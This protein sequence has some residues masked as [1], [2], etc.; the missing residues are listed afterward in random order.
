MMVMAFLSA[1]GLL[2]WLSIRSASMEVDIVEGA[3]V[4]DENVSTRVAP[5]VFGSNPMAQADILIELRGLRVEGPVGSEAFF[6]Q[7]P[8]QGSYLVKM[9]PEVM[10]DGL[11]I[12]SDATVTVTGRVHEMS[13]SVADAWVASGAIA[14][15]DRILAI[16]AETFLE[17]ERVRVTAQPEPDAN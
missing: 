7:V 16:F 4:V 9:P 3:A 12:E 14:E 5:D 6:L 15:S 8:N 11:E 13:D 2:Y 17:V 10:A 1:A